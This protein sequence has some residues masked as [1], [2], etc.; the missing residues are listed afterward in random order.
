[1]RFHI[2]AVGKVQGKAKS[3]WYWNSSKER[4]KI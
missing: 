4:E 2:Q 1:M 3:S